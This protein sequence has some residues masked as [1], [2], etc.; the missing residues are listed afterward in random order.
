MRTTS[1]SSSSSSILSGSLTDLQRGAGPHNFQDLQASQQSHLSAVQSHLNFQSSQ[2]FP[3]M[4]SPPS[5]PFRGPA[6]SASS[7]FSK[8]PFQLRDG[9]FPIGDALGEQQ[10]Q[11]QQ[12]PPSSSGA[13]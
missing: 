9:F 4:T 6:S 11:Q 2:L 8:I 10:Q 7:S 1:S 3:D 12:L 13:G 5:N